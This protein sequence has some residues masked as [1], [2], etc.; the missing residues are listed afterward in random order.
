M[1]I[2]ISHDDFLKYGSNITAKNVLICDDGISLE[3]N[4]EG[5]KYLA[6]N[7][8]LVKRL[9]KTSFHFIFKHKIGFILGFFL[10]LGNQQVIKEKESAYVKAE[11]RIGLG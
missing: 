7:N 6:L 8:V 9:D 11:D 3:T 5:L 1:Q 10:F 2:K 4:K